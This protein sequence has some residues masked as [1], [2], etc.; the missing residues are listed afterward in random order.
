MAT[1]VSD[2]A[3]QLL[4]DAHG[5]EQFHYHKLPV[6]LTFSAPVPVIRNRR[7]IVIADE[8]NV[9]IF[10]SRQGFACYTFYHYSGFRLTQLDITKLLSIEVL[11]PKEAEVDLA[12]EWVKIANRIHPNAWPRLKEELL[13]KPQKWA[14][15]RG[16][17]RTV[18][19]TSTFGKRVAEQLKGA[20]EHRRPFNEVLHGPKRRKSVSCIV[21]DSGEFQAFYSS[22]Y[23]GTLNGDY[24]LL[25]NPTTAIF[26][27][28]D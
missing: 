27:E 7:K 25:I 15:E 26:Y 23:A 17:P 28:K 8:H 9:K 16:R 5:P 4:I 6:R 1:H 20:F 22:E 21:L 24:Y 19:M 11:D 10:W 3:K 13:A 18:S 14:E 2:L 12:A